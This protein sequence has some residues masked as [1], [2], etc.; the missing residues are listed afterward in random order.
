MKARSS[1]IQL[2]IPGGKEVV[3]QYLTYLN[4]MGGKA[5]DEMVC[6][7]NQGKAWMLSYMVDNLKARI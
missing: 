2:L 7:L 5:F 1:N 4:A 6:R 3:V